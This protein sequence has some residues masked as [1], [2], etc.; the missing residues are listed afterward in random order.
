MTDSSDGLNVYHDAAFDLLTKN[1]ND[2]DPSMQYNSIPCLPRSNFHSLNLDSSFKPDSGLLLLNIAAYDS[3]QFVFESTSG[4]EK[5]IFRSLRT[6]EVAQQKC[7][8][9]GPSDIGVHFD[10]VPSNEGDYYV[11]ACAT[12]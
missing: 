9:S 7:T 4:G 8:D 6:R 2:T 10:C 12:G 11:F 3:A 1:E 5:G